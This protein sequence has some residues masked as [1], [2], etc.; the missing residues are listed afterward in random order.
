MRNSRSKKIKIS[1]IIEARMGSKRLPGKVLM[2]ILDKPVLQHIYERLSKSIYIDQIIIATTDQSEDLQIIE[3]AKKNHISFYSGYENDLIGRVYE[4]AITY[5]SDV[6]VEICGDC[7][8]ID[9]RFVDNCITKYLNSKYDIVTNVLSRTFP[10]GLE[11]NIFSTQLLSLVNKKKLS[12]KYREHLCSYI[13]DNP[14][15][16]KI[17]S[18]SA[19]RKYCYPDIKLTLDTNED[20][21]FIKNIFETLYSKKKMIMTEDVINYVNKKMKK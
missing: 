8:L 18:I 14:K 20:Y 4:C 7:P 10:N 12:Q 3:Y 2:N 19:E 6:I 1:A 9:Y 13:L 15:L 5:E 17:K 11:T 16:F 21:N